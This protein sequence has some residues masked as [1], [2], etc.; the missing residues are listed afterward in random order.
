MSSQPTEASAPLIPMPSL[1]P[2]ALRAAVAEIVPSRLP[3]LNEHLARAATSAQRTS[4]V[5]PLRA[6]T[7]HWGT[8][9]NIERWP[10]RAARFH[11][12]EELAADPLA[13]PEDARAAASEIGHILRTAGEEIGV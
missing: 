5:G 1:T 3:E 9:V 2:D 7:A 6:F 10:Q 8:V 4:S 13:D 11:S 12:C